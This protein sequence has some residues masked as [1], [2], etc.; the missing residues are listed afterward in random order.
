MNDYNGMYIGIVVKNNDPEKRGRVKI[1][2]PHINVNVYKDW[3]R[4]DKDKN[5]AGI[6]PVHE[7][8]DSRLQHPLAKVFFTVFEHT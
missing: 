2:V 5:H 7:R 1:Y 3:Y 4:D 8:N 6:F